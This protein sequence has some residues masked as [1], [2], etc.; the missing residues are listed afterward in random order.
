MKAPK[1]LNDLR[2]DHRVEEVSDERGSGDGIW[3][4]LTK[5]WYSEMTGN[6]S[7]AADLSHTI[8]EQTVEKCWEQMRHIAAN[9]YKD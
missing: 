7:S 9:P 8:H 4:Y 6:H 2:N 1:T 5:D 3:V